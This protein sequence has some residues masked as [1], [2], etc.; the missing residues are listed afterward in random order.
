MAYDTIR[1]RVEFLAAVARGRGSA[2]YLEIG[3]QDRTQCFDHIPAARKWGVD[4]NGGG[5]TH[6]QTSDAFFASIPKEEA[7]DLIFIDGDHHH[8]QVCRDIDNSLR[9]LAPGGVLVMHDC[10]PLTRGHENPA[11]CY[12]AWRAFAKLR[13]RPDVE[14][15]CG[16]FDHG[17][18][19]ARRAKN[20]APIRL[21]RVLNALTY[22]DFL[23]H[24][25]AWFRP[26]SFED[27]LSFALEEKVPPAVPAA[28]DSGLTTQ[29]FHRLLSGETPLR[30]GQHR[31][32]FG[33][34][35][36]GGPGEIAHQ[37]DHVVSASLADLLCNVRRGF[38]P[39]R[40]L[41]IGVC[42][43][44]SLALWRELWGAEVIGIDNNYLAT[45]WT[46]AHFAEEGIRMVG[47]TMP[48]PAVRQLGTFDLIIDDGPHGYPATKPAFD[49]LWPM[50]RPGGLYI[51][52]DWVQQFLEP[53]RTLQLISEPLIGDWQ[54]LDTG[55]TA[56]YRAHLYRGLVALD[57]KP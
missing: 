17:V 28:E 26:Q 44:G 22:D 9:H 1:T 5:A 40:V 35:R 56:P 15:F 47:M 31:L 11:L 39:A 45:P 42:A 21:P 48:N 8:D 20:T 57:K 27:L 10:L 23:T 29:D 7:F 54:A 52:E 3:V 53:A 13:E 37:K 51:I 6:R 43:G 30:C 18:G 49:L 41:E 38:R 14:A 12:T 34:G 4:P 50:L 32:V 19:V 33:G 24:R 55:P 25:T 16:D 2:R 36:V 46:D